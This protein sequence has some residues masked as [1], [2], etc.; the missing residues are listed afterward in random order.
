MNSAGEEAVEDPKVFAVSDSGTAVV[1]R[2]TM[3]DMSL[4]FDSPIHDAENRT[5]RGKF[6]CVMQYVEKRDAY[7]AAVGYKRF[8][9]RILM[10]LKYCDFPLLD[11]NL[12]QREN[13]LDQLR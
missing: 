6:D 3:K 5:I 8:A 9:D 1:D 13:L 10:L 4:A 7:K 12:E 11:E 2:N